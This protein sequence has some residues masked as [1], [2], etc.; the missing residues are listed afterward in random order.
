MNKKQ[1]LGIDLGTSNCAI[2]FTQ[3]KLTT[4]LDITQLAAA[5]RVSDDK[6][7]ASALFIPGQ[8]QFSAEAVALPWKSPHPDY[9]F[10]NFA[11]HLGATMPD[12][13][14]SSAKSWLCS[15]SIDPTSP[16]LPFNSSS[17]EQKLSPFEVTVLYLEYLRHAFDYHCTQNNRPVSLAETEVVITVPASFD[18]ASRTLTAE[19]AK[20]A[21]WGDQIILLEEPQA[22]FYAWLDTMGSQWRTQIKPGDLILVCDV[23]GGTTDFSLIAV[24]QQNGNLDLE[25]ISVGDHILLGGDNMD[26]ALAFTL[27]DNLENSK[28]TIDDWQFLSLIHSCRKAKELMFEA[29]QMEQ[30]TLAIPSRGSNLFAK[31]I[32][33][34]VTREIL[35]QVIVDGFFPIT[36]IDDMPQKNS[37]EGLREFGLPYAADAAISKHLAAFLTKSVSVLQADSVR[38]TTTLEGKLLKGEKASL[39]CPDAVLFNGGVFKGQRLR[40]R[41]LELLTAW[42]PEK[43]IREL[44]GSE[45]DLAVSRGASHYGFIKSSNAGIRIRAGISRSYYLGLESSMPAIPGYKPPIKAVCVAEQGMEE[46]QERVLENKEFG[47]VI[48]ATVFFRFFS[49][50]KHASDSVGVII[51]NAEKELEESRRLE[52]TIEPIDSLGK[53]VLI[54][55]KLHTRLSE[56][57]TLALWMQHTRSEK[58]WELTFS[59]RTE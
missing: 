59:V 1:A 47:L 19:A 51:T 56:L 50:T 30:H 34:N 4:G 17:V 55:V 43:N 16:I 33:T 7:F 42:A 54:P 10:G 8:Q 49:S 40:Q 36:A 11:R 25:R 20:K 14:V 24:S 3:D 31:T 48:G 35:D 9:L 29:P 28:T 2:A 45:Y 39:L 21:G 26:L 58:R 46:G 27:R 57:G 37:S 52:M 18:E 23:G 32:T 6:T 5:N 44:E 15:R 22:A 38:A 53:N 13:L 41:I 12:R